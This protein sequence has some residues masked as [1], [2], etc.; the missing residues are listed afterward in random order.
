VP[1]SSAAS[2]SA[3]LFQTASRQQWE[4]LTPCRR[5]GVATPLF[6][7]YSRA[8]IGIGEFK[9]LLRLGSW[10]RKAGLS[11]IQLLPMND[12]GF[13]FRPYD[14][15]SSFALEP[16]YVS[17]ED[18]KETDLRPFRK[19]IKTL[20]QRFPCGRKQVNYGIK[21]AKLEILWDIFKKNPA[22]KTRHLATFVRE[23]KHWL[24][25]YALFKTLKEE[26]GEKSWQDWEPG[27]K[28]RHDANLREFKERHGKRI[29]F[30]KWVQ[31]QAYKQFSAIKKELARKNLFLMGDLPFLV[32]RDSADVWA[33]QDLFKLDLSAG[34]PPDMVF[35]QGQ[36]WGMPPFNWDA[37]ERGNYRHLIDRLEYAQNFYDL[38][39]LDH[40][41]G[42]FRVWTVPLSGQSG[43]AGAFDPPEEHLWEEH[44]RKL[45]SLMLKHSRLL[46]CA[47]D[48]GTVPDCSYKVLAELGIPG[49]EIQRWARN[50]KGDRDF[51]TPETYRLLSLATLSTHD[52]S[53]FTG[54]WNFEAGTVDEYTVRKRCEQKG[55]H[56]IKLKA[57]LFD[58]SRSRYGK[59]HWKKDARDIPPELTDLYND[60]HD[61][62]ERFWKHVGLTGDADETAS[63]RL[64]QA[65]LL[66]VNKTA[67]VFSV[68]LLQDWLS[69]DESLAI[70][71][72]ESRINFPGTTGKNNWAVTAPIPLEKINRLPINGIIRQLNKQTGRTP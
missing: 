26:H 39:R 29:R 3:L 60:S 50:W 13:D 18:L 30:H 68:Q 64:V 56:F 8:S 48:L 51:K 11:L 21:R 67:S 9:D 28:E 72:W 17:L 47:E 22:A 59:L 31:W 1:D 7:L 71:P 36:I 34:A 66:T 37:I 65:A 46:P 70:D 42:L 2:L 61:E 44:G 33:H 69:L 20:R 23:N 41:V 54:W 4:R 43:S 35:S 16:M 58:L 19:T 14:A 5:A 27:L 63:P 53:S 40:A 15:Q 45:L 10:C 52:I 62:K 49:M 25:D 57:H 38:F 24:E 55:M 6:S 12:V 32:S